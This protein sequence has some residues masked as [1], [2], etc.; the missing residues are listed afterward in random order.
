MEKSNEDLALKI[1]QLEGAFPLILKQLDTIQ[2]NHLVHIQAS[3]DANQKQHSDIASQMQAGF[4]T[5]NEKID[6]IKI[7]IARWLGAAAVVVFVLGLVA[8]YIIKHF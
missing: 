6:S 8:Q 4:Q 3:L 1:G 5:Y 2:N 7:V